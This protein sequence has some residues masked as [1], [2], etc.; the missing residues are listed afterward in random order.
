MFWVISPVRR[1]W[2]S[3]STRARWPPFGSA[4]QVGAARRNFQASIRTAAD[5]TYSSM[6]NIT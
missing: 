1:P 5:A 2:R 6:S 4:V 3:R